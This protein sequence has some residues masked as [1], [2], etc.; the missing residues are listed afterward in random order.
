MSY[1]VTISRRIKAVQT[2]KITSAMRLISRAFHIKCIKTCCINQLS[3][4]TYAYF[5]IFYMH[6]TDLESHPFFTKNT[7]QN[8]YQIFIIIGSQKGLCGTYNNDL[9]Y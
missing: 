6:S 2:I 7:E 3:K 5:F 1:L 9:V 4:R 8:A